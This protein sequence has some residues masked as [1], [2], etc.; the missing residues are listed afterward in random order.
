MG[1][2]RG[3]IKGS[4]LWLVR[5]ALPVGTRDFCPDLAT[6]IGPVQNIFFPTGYY[7]NSFVPIAQQAGQAAV[8]GGLSVNV[9]L[10][11]ESLQRNCSS[12][13]SMI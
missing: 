1:P 10:W 2:Q 6:L 7:L 5:W 9:C 13:R 12:T 3:Q 4:F 8:L 11:D